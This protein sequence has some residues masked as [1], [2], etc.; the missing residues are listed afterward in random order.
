MI[1]SENNIRKI[2]RKLLEGSFD[3]ASADGIRFNFGSGSSS[4]NRG[5]ST[6]D[7]PIDVDPSKLQQGI[8]LVSVN[9]ISNETGLRADFIY[10]IQ[11]RESAGAASAMAL[12]PHITID[13]KGY[14]WATEHAGL[15]K[16][17]GPEGKEKW[18]EAVRSM[19]SA[20]VERDSIT[21]AHEA[22]GFKHPV[23]VQM[24]NIDHELAILGNALG[25]YQVL[26]AHLLPF[27]NHSAEELEQAFISDPVTFSRKA[28]VVWVNKHSDFIEKVNASEDNW[29]EQITR[30]YGENNDDYTTHVKRAAKQY[31]E[32]K[33]ENVDG[34]DISEIKDGAGQIWSPGSQLKMR[35]PNFFK[36]ICDNK[37]N[38]RSGEPKN[39]TSEFF[40][41]LNQKYGINTVITLNGK[42][43]IQNAVSDA[44]LN[45]I[46]VYLTNKPPNENEWNTIK[47]ALKRGNTL[48]HCTHGADR[49]GA[50]IAKYEI[51]ECSKNPKAA[52]DDALTYGFKKK[53]FAYSEQEPDPNKKLRNW[54]YP[55]ATY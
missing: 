48:I 9:N 39:V 26:G 34:G 41:S 36:I 45:P 19:K 31:R 50:I 20:G 38:Y 54:F 5:T 46:S 22:G 3:S 53:D 10:G 25:Y 43:D 23:Y 16:F 4:D 37:N 14:R 24:K 40:E 7:I 44:G 55:N 28:F 30:Y 6:D 29:A 17:L 11:S 32:A 49:T 15:V 27:Y 21:M 42:Q 8:D 47:T 51:E 13:S 33:I 12:N 35:Q 2:I 1:I 18:S 52:Y